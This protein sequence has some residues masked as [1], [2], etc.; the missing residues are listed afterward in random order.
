L[1]T[2]QRRWCRSAQV[3]ALNAHTLLSTQV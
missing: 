2:F 1:Y 3:P